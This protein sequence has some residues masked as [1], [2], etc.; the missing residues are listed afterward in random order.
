[1]SRPSIFI[2]ATALVGSFLLPHG[3]NISCAVL[4][5]A[6][7]ILAIFSVCDKRSAL[8]CTFSALIFLALILRFVF[9]ST[10][11]DNKT[12]ILNKK[13]VQIEGIVTSVE[14]SSEDFDIYTIKITKSSDKNAKNLLVRMM[15]SDYKNIRQGDKIEAGVTFSPISGE[16]KHSYY[17][18]GVYY[19]CRVSEDI[20]VSPDRPFTVHLI[21]DILRS[22][23]K[24]T[25]YTNTSGEEAA[26]LVALIMGDQSNLSARLSLNVKS[27]GVSHMLVVSGMHLGII[28]GFLLNVLRRSNAGTL[29]SAVACIVAIVLISLIC[30]FHISILRAGIVFI[31]MLLGRLIYR[32]SD[33]LN[34]LGI[35]IVLLTFIYPYLFYSVAFLLSITATFAVVSPGKKLCEMLDLKSGS[36]PV[37]KLLYGVW[38]IFVISIAALI[39]TLPITVK[40]FGT[41]ALASP[42]ANLAVNFLISA[43]LVLGIIAVLLSF[44]PLL[45]LIGR[46]LFLIT[47]GLIG[48]F[49]RIV[50]FIGSGRFRAIYVSSDLYIYFL[51]FAVIFVI[52]VNYFYKRKKERDGAKNAERENT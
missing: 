37:D 10:E 13:Q 8:K 22:R 26:V 32:N 7:V 16:Y 24:S 31:I 41:A 39:C 1:M 50:D 48:L 12:E 2:G 3:A 5:F 36:K 51:F 27:A 52:A 11:I 18:D 6:A 28:C 43:A 29:A 46:L 19:Y 40:Y 9:L 33:P 34:S 21:S 14:Y 23:M 38:N 47:E 35:A 25:I 42:L 4:I 17:A 30:L 44:I 49:I 15:V 20:S 45:S